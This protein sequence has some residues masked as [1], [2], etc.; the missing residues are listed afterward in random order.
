MANGYDPRMMLAQSLMQRQ[1]QPAYGFIGG[2]TNALTP[3]A[4]ALMARGAQRQQTKRQEAETSAMGRLLAEAE[5]A[6]SEGGDVAG[7]V[8]AMLQENRGKPGYGAAGER[9]MGSYQDQLAKNLM[10][11]APKPYTDIAKLNADLE[12]GRITQPQFDQAMARKARPEKQPSLT[13]RMR[14]VMATG[15]DPVT[16]R[17]YSESEQAAFAKAM[18]P[19]S[20]NTREDFLRDWTMANARNFRTGPEVMEEGNELYDMIQ[21]VEPEA[22][23]LAQDIGAVEAAVP[24]VAA[25]PAGP[26]MPGRKPGAVKPTYGS[27]T[28]PLPP[29]EEEPPAPG[30]GAL[31]PEIRQRADSGTFTEEDLLELQRSDPEQFEALYRYLKGE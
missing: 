7:A 18:A 19:G 23:G 16:G 17:K 11:P 20:A 15:K 1:P 21:G 4:G 30:G 25:V 12:A 31:M 27:A 24:P 26:P 13:G 10:A 28:I 6:R 8:N 9:F 22:V 3:I 5:R 14:W 29:M 2:L